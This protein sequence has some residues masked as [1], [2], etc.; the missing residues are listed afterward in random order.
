[1]QYKG[2]TALVYGRLE[3]Q[4]VSRV[5]HLEEVPLCKGQSARNPLL[6]LMQNVQLHQ[7][8]VEILYLS[9]L[10]MAMQVCCSN[11]S[12]SALYSNKVLMNRISKVE[13]SK[14]GRPSRLQSSSKRMSSS[15]TERG[16]SNSKGTGASNSRGRRGSNSWGR[17]ASNS[18]LNK[19]SSN[20]ENSS[21][22]AV[23]LH[24]SRLL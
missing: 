2:L 4:Q 22:Q 3:Q 20:K 18:R 9:F 15:G 5:W 19:I 21:S 6:Q 16:A 8:L 14:Q 11:S 7:V 23:G 1:M 17:G 12:S 13:L 24:G 10:V